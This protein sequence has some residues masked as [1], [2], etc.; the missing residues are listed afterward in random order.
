M[1][2]QNS[3]QSH[4]VRGLVAVAVAP[5]LFVAACGTDKPD[6]SGSGR[7][8]SG[9]NGVAGKSSSE[10]LAAAEQ[11]LKSAQS[12]HLKGALTDNGETIKLNLWVTRT[13]A[14]GSISAP[15]GGKT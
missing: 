1:A 9:G 10:I 7:P 5:T 14:K 2:R 3:M 8:A 12:V 4:V 6:T 15:E 13:Q 11:A